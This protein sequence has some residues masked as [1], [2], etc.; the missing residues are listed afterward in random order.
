MSDWEKRRDEAYE[1]RERRSSRIWF[2]VWLVAVVLA[3][4]YHNLP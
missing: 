3:V 4:I 2:S 1:K